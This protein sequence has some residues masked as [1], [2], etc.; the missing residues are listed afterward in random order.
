MHANLGITVLTTFINKNFGSME[1]SIRCGVLGKLCGSVRRGLAAMSRPRVS[2]LT[3][4][5]ANWERIRP[6]RRVVDDCWALGDGD[7][8]PTGVA[9]TCVGAFAAF[10][11]SGRTFFG[12]QK[13]MKL[14]QVSAHAAICPFDPSEG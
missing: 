13:N 1:G 5:S 10:I 8:G 2:F 14:F 3:P 7:A 12:N 4:A 11:V 6:K 9:P